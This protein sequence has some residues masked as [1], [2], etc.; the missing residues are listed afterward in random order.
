MDKSIYYIDENGILRTYGLEVTG[1]RAIG[2]SLLFKL[3]Y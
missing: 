3:K 2:L 1:I